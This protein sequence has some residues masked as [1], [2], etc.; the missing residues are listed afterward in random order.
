MNCKEML[1]IWYC[2]SIGN[3]YIC[4]YNFTC[5]VGRFDMENKRVI[6]GHSCIRVESIYQ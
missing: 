3:F 6:E 5:L 4:L 1:K 2:N